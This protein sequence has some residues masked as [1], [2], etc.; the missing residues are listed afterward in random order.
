MNFT[1]FKI[2]SFDFLLKNFYSLL[3]KSK[4]SGWFGNYL[5]WEEAKILC[6]G[7]DDI[8]ILE[9][10]KSSVLKVKNG[11]AVY[12]RDSVLF[13]KIEYSK[14][15]YNVFDEILS[16]NS[17][18]LNVIDF[19]G[20]LGSSYFQYKSLLKNLQLLNWQVVEQKHFVEAGNSYIADK[21][22]KFYNSID[23]ALVHSKNPVLF[24]S[25][26]LQYLE[27]P[28]DFIDKIINYNFEYIILD[29]TAF[30]EGSNDRITIQIVPETIYKA[31][32]PAWFFNEQNL[33]SCFLKKYNLKSQFSSEISDSIKLKDGEIVNWKGF[34]FKR[35][36]D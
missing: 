33:L 28:Y 12:E 26:V 31:S 1:E 8:L 27:K 21:N 11:E 13:D 4:S 16:I 5:N 17:G 22:L 25:G 18:H 9:K 3:G 36:N 6:T 20:S 19:G 14:P 7:Y 35:K 30:I 24:L 23:E 10:V 29:R 2:K 15:V 32:Y 34:I